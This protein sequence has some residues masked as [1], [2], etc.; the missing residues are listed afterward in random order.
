[1]PFKETIMA[2]TSKILI[3][4]TGGTIGMQPTP[5]GLAPSPGLLNKHLNQISGIPAFDL[6][7]LS[8]LIDSSSIQY[9]HWNQITELI[10]KNVPDYQGFVVVHGTDTMA[11]TCAALSYSLAKL[12]KPL[13]VTGSMYPLEVE[14]SDAMG[15]LKLACQ[16]AGRSEIKGVRLAFDQ[17][18]LIGSQVTKVSSFDKKAFAAP[19]FSGV[20]HPD[21]ALKAQF[22]KSSF[23]ETRIGVFVLHP[24][25]D[26]KNLKWMVK[27]DYQAIVLKTYGSG[28]VMASE[29]LLECLEI[30]QQNRI[31]MV[32]TSQCLQAN[33]D[34]SIYEAGSALSNLGVLSAKT[35]THE[36]TVTKLQF[37]F[38]QHQSIEWVKEHFVTNL[39]QEMPELQ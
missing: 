38:S 19:H 26:L 29:E 15:N 31:V 25:P 12:S 37:L 30:A 9:H 17:Q 11:Y 10:E 27:Q 32:N 35:M 18:L 2:P 8:P 4:Y 21:S 3:I 13:V 5:N 6:I 14:K 36:A 22:V 20:S 34:M 24:T 16:S 33:V 23:T 28:N 1:M 7:E 39:A